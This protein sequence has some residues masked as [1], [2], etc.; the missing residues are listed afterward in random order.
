MYVQWKSATD[1]TRACCIVLV[2]LSERFDWSVPKADPHCAL[3]REWQIA[4]YPSPRASH[5]TISSET[6]RKDTCRLRCIIV[7]LQDDA[8]MAEVV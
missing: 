3:T 4:V 8:I 2:S 7:Q 6:L 1:I 5:M